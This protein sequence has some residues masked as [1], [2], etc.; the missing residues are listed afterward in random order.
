MQSTTLTERVGRRVLRLVSAAVLVF[1]VAPVLIVI[2]LSFNESAY[3]SYPMSGFSTR[4]YAALVSS[5]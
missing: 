4:W 1:L 2:P 3:F 5:E